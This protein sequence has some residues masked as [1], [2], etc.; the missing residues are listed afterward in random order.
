MKPVTAIIGNRIDVFKIV[1]SVEVNTNV[2]VR[3]VLNIAFLVSLLPSSIITP[4]VYSEP[5]SGKGGI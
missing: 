4:A 1:R 5:D 2:D 3:A